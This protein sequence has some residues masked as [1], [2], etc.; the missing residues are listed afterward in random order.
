MLRKVLI[1]LVFLIFTPITTLAGDQT[2]A[3]GPKEGKY[4]CTTDWAASIFPGYSFLGLSRLTQKQLRFSITLRK[5]YQHR[6][7]CFSS[8]TI[9]WLKDYQPPPAGEYSIDE[10]LDRYA[11]CLKTP[12]CAPWDDPEGFI[13]S[14]LSNFTL[15]LS[16]FSM[17]M[18]SIDGN[19]FFNQAGNSL[20][21]DGSVFWLYQ[22]VF[23]V[24]AYGRCNFGDSAPAPSSETLSA[25]TSASPAPG[26]SQETVGA[27]S[28]PA[29]TS[30]T[31]GG[32]TQGGTTHPYDDCILKYM[33]SAQN[34]EAV[35]A[36]ERSCINKSSVPIAE[37]LIVKSAYAGNYND[38]FGSR[39]KGL[40]ISI[41]N[42]TKFDI[43]EITVTLTNKANGETDSYPVTLF[44][45]PSAGITIELPE[46]GLV[47]V[48]KNSSR[49]FL[50]NMD[51]LRINMDQFAKYY[52]WDLTA[53]RGIPD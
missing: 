26:Q 24:V 31:S 3:R 18:D 21:F 23:S 45:E 53:T 52:D 19:R 1:G 48:K 17:Y 39:V 41:L 7:E 13:S 12:G 44:L 15:E 49:T 51:D 11:K 37:K 28:P 27:S 50:V 43:T 4:M 25:A 46:P 47:T 38:G 14:C 22:R 30:G 42:N 2:T 34:K 16:G 10:A 20:D 40:V 5:A 32:T 6:D 9:K 35:Y 33:G 29:D 8:D 36:I